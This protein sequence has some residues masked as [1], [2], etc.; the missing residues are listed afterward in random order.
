MVVLSTIDDGH[1]EPFDASQ[2]FIHDRLCTLKFEV[3]EDHRRSGAPAW[4]VR[5]SASL[6]VGFGLWACFGL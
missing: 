3:P 5:Q 6:E 1:T 2:G 4:A